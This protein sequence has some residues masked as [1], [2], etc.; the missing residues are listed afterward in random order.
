M[1][2]CAGVISLRRVGVWA[3]WKDGPRMKKAI[4]G[5]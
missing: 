2:A 4:D 3:D 1:E 5:V